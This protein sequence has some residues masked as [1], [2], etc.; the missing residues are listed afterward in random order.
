MKQTIW[1][2]SWNAGGYPAES[3]EIQTTQKRVGDFVY[4]P[5]T[6]FKGAGFAASIRV[7]D[8]VKSLSIGFGDDTSTDLTLADKQTD[9][10]TLAGFDIYRKVRLNT[11]RTCNTVIN[12]TCTF[13]ADAFD[14]AEF[15]QSLHQ[16]ADVIH[17][18][19]SVKTATADT[20]QIQQASVDTLDGS[21][22]S[23]SKDHVTFAAEEIRF[24]QAVLT[25]DSFGSDDPFTLRSGSSRIK[26]DTDLKKWVMTNERSGVDAPIITLYASPDDTPK[27]SIPV[28]LASDPTSIQFVPWLSISP[29][30]HAVIMERLRVGELRISGT[31]ITS[32]TGMTLS[33]G[34]SNIVL[35]PDGTITIGAVRFS[36]TEQAIKFGD[37]S[38]N[39][40]LINT[41]ITMGNRLRD[42]QKTVEDLKT[43][44]FTV[45]ASIR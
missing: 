25:K 16:S 12:C 20:A 32:D 40:E 2:Y 33:S 1:K 28:I 26:Y 13:I 36:S 31:T 4:L 27:Y 37:V 17:K 29:E 22:G 6:F 42:V 9:L 24:G 23:V 10:S 7:S 8:T 30:D 11:A 43:E 45:K 35:S 18:S 41:I 5:H 3:F 14:P 39:K 21:W 44:L 38:I 19:I 34:P 15:G